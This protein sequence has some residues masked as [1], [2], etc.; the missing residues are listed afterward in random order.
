M[1]NSTEAAR[2]LET[3][4]GANWTDAN[5]AF[6]RELDSE[7]DNGQRKTRANFVRCVESTYDRLVGPW[8]GDDNPVLQ[9]LP[10]GLTVE[11]AR[12]LAHLVASRRPA[13]LYLALL[14][15]AQ[16]ERK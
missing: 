8:A 4:L 9:Y 13:G 16:R 10:D 2:V 1:K 12:T 11:Q 5:A 3:K 15:V 14:V 6:N 7:L